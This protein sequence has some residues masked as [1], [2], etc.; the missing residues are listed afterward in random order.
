MATISGELYAMPR[1]GGREADRQ[2]SNLLLEQRV[3]ALTEELARLRNERAVQLGEKQAL[4]SHLRNVLDGLPVAVVVLDGSGVITEC[5]QAATALFSDALLGIAWR[6]VIVRDFQPQPQHNHDLILK[7]GRIVALSTCPLGAAPG[8]ILL[9]EDVTDMRRAQDTL[10]RQQRILDLGQM[11]ANIAHQIRTPL[12]SALLYVSHL[13]RSDL[14]IDVQQRFAAKAVRS[15][16]QLESLV[17]NMLLFARGEI[18]NEQV[19]RADGL[20]R[21]LHAST[22]ALFSGTA[23][24]Y[25]VEDVCTTAEIRVNRTMM[26]SA[27]Q[28]LVSNAAQSVG[29]TGQVTLYCHCTAADSV[30]LGIRDDGPGVAP[31]IQEHLFTPFSTTRD[32]GTGLGLAIVRAIARAHHGEVWFESN[33]GNTTFAVRLPAVAARGDGGDVAEHERDEVA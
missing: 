3:V 10:A 11:A 33:P 18:G 19:M 26:L 27:L 6:D 23:V 17:A 25:T 7:T 5:N 31:A 12:A 24:H 16:R 21:E 20:L 2:D 29:A 15:L 32:A 8:Q 9:F 28:N 22:A 13:E 4:A 30:D 1:P 14:T